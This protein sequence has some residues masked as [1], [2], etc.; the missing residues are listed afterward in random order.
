MKKAIVFESLSGNTKLL[1]EAVQGAL[2]EVDY[3]GGPSDEALTKDALYLGFWTDKGSCTP[4]MAKFM[5]DLHGKDIFLFGT[6]GFGGDSA[7]FEQIL[8]RVKENLPEDNKVIGSFMCQG[9]M[10]QSVR[11]R[12]EKMAEDPAMKEKM[13]MMIQ[14][15]DKAL[16]H[17]NEE[18]VANLVKAL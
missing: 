9:K 17:P 3:F 10:P 12:Y 1:A 7:Y 5:Q 8:A 18:D 14:N 2:G 15:F 4:G 16:A 11:A 13:T 6:A